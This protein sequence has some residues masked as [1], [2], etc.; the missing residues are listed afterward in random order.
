MTES[1]TNFSG[2]RNGWVGLSE[3]I[4]ISTSDIWHLPF[5]PFLSEL[6]SSPLHG[7]PAGLSNRSCLFVFPAIRESGESSRHVINPSTALVKVGF[8]RK[9]SELPINCFSEYGWHLIIGS[10]PLTISKEMNSCSGIHV[11][12]SGHHDRDLGREPLPRLANISSPGLSI[13]I[14]RTRLQS[15]QPANLRKPQFILFANAVSSLRIA[16]FSLFWMPSDP[17]I[18]E[19]VR[20]SSGVM[21]FQVIHHGVPPRLR[22]TEYGLFHRITISKMTKNFPNMRWTS[23]SG[24]G[25]GYELVRSLLYILFN[26]FWVLPWLHLLSAGALFRVSYPRSAPRADRLEITSARTFF[27]R[28]VETLNNETQLD[29]ER[30]ADHHSTESNR[31][32]RRIKIYEQ[33]AKLR[34]WERSIFEREPVSADGT[35]REWRYAEIAAVRNDPRGRG[36]SSTNKTI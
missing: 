36:R 15:T 33:E 18:H 23:K 20:S 2:R 8:M 26:F 28:S 5:L 19:K 27:P 34:W 32:L 31:D 4:S 6:I 7:K 13:L 21:T 17:W 10:R 30:T 25:Q 24:L 35:L 29:N 14:L 3:N 12:V 11:F 1:R 16:K 9:V 22:I